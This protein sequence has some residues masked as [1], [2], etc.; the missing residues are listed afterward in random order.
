MKTPKMKKLTLILTLL[1]TLSVTA[2]NVFAQ[3]FV[4]TSNTT[5]SGT[6]YENSASQAALTNS[7]TW[8]FTGSNLTL[9]GTGADHGYSG[10]TFAQEVNHCLPRAKVQIVK[11]AEPAAFV[12]LPKRWIVECTFAWLEK[13]RRRWKNC[14]RLLNSSLQFA[15]LALLA[16]LLKRL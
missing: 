16:L 9:T 14:E 13:H 12:V 8:N 2:L 3:N 1:C 6:H 15:V 7:S 10:A 4:V 11:R 5:V